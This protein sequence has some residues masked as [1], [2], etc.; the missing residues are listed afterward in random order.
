MGLRHWVRRSHWLSSLD[1]I[2]CMG[3]GD[4][5]RFGVPHNA[6]SSILLEE[7]L[8][9]EAPQDRLGFLC[10]PSGFCADAL[11]CARLVR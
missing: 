5:F 4:R 6:N 2:E 1:T 10:R 9:K 7:E 8:T 3:G 11:L